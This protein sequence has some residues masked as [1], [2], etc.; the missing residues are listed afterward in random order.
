MAEQPLL[1]VIQL[2]LDRNPIKFSGLFSHVIA[3]KD[4]NRRV[5]II[6]LRVTLHNT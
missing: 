2:P 4:D 1:A 5:V 3:S 6:G